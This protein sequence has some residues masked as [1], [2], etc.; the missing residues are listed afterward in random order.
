MYLNFIYSLP[1]GKKYLYNRLMVTGIW[2]VENIVKNLLSS[3]TFDFFA[4]WEFKSSLRR[5]QSKANQDRQTKNKSP[6]SLQK[7]YWKKSIWTINRE[8]TDLFH[9]LSLQYNTVQEPVLK[10]TEQ[11]KIL[12]IAGIFLRKNSTVERAVAFWLSLENLNS[13][14]VVGWNYTIQISSLLTMEFGFG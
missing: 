9:R 14:I 11:M 3:F 7:L 8:K 1:L 10:K 2:N 5:K 12:W 13:S 4:K 6:N